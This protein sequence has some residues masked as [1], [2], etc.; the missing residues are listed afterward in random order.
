M[1]LPENTS[2]GSTIWE[3]GTVQDIFCPPFILVET[4]DYRSGIK[5]VHGALVKNQPAGRN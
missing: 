2:V 4:V 1:R 3:N 5:V